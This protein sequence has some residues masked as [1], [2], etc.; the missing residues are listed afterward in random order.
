MQIYHIKCSI[1][2]P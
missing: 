1:Y 2:Y